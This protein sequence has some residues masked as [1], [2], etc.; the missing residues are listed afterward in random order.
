MPEFL[1]A[2]AF[3]L[4]PSRV[5]LWGQIRF[6]VQGGKPQALPG[7]QVSLKK[8]SERGGYVA[9][10]YHHSAQGVENE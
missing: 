2:E 4:S 8:G 7:L 1:Q 5:N 10:A 9:A 3:F 6:G